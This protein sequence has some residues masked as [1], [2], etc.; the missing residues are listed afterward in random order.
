MGGQRVMGRQLGGDLHGGL[1]RD[2]LGLIYR[3]QF[4]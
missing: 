1:R 2:A 3:R 4:I